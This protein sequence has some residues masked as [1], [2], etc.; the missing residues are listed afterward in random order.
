M[1]TEV[2]VSPVKDEN[3]K[4]HL[5][6]SPVWK[7]CYHAD[8]VTTEIRNKYPKWFEYS[9]KFEGLV[10]FHLTKVVEK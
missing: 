7:N 1:T 4:A 9:I 3:F 5:N 10:P 8:E 2:V 6:D